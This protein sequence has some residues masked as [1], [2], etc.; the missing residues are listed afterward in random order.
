MMASP[1]RI[2]RV[3]TSKVFWFFFSKKNCFLSS[4]DRVAPAGAGAYLCI[5]SGG[6]FMQ[7][8]GGFPV[9]LVLFAMIAAFL[10]LRLRSILGKRTGF[11]G[12]PVAAPT[13]P[14]AAG[15]VIDGRAEP[16]P[17]P[18]PLPAADS[19]AGQALAA[20][21]AADRRFDAAKFIAGAEAAFRVIVAAFAAGDR[22]RLR[23][24]LGD[25]TYA[26]FDHAIAA[27]DAAGETQHSEIRDVLEAEIR[28][29]R[30]DG[31][32]ASITVHFVSRQVSYVTARDGSTVGGTDAMTEIADLWT[33]ARVLDSSDVSWHLVD[34]KVA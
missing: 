8:I 12:T 3:Q 11:E 13:P 6:V 2:E 15:P 19:P 30:L 17:P 18:R 25:A 7:A 26:A 5:L 23:P 31:K 1:V 29:A 4:P 33:F 21:Q 22:V 28:E 24:L 16:A 20:I 10:V 9:D 34:A 32:L 27:R 14:V